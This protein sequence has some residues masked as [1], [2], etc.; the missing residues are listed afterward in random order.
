M[1]IFLFGSGS[2]SRKSSTRSES[3]DVFDADDVFDEEWLSQVVIAQI[4]MMK[5]YYNSDIVWSLCV[6]FPTQPVP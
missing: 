4:T 3:N 2:R 5:H 6:M 1:N